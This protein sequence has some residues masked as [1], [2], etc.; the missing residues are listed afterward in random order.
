MNKTGRLLIS[1]GFILSLGA[2]VSGLLL[3]IFSTPSFMSITTGV[4]LS[5]AFLVGAILLAAGRAI[6]RK[7]GIIV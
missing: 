4:C 5:C 1:I 3:L 6:D 7:N 2:V